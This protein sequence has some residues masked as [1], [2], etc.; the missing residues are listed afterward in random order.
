MRLSD[1]LARWKEHGFKSVDEK[2]VF[3]SREFL[4]SELDSVGF[5]HLSKKQSQYYSDPDPLRIRD[6]FPELGYDIECAAKCLAVKQATAAV[7]HLMRTMEESLKVLGGRLGIDLSGTRNWQPLLD[8]VNKAIARLPPSAARKTE[9]A[10]L[11]SHLFH[12]KMA[13]RNPTMHPGR[14]YDADQAEE[15]FH[16]VGIYLRGLRSAAPPPS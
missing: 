8:Q 5:L 7:F 11:A 12:V 2:E 13:W 3:L 14:Q 10:A 16:T 1:L 15:I 4:R 9:L 6:A